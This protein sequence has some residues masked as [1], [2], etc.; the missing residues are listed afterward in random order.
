MSNGRVAKAIYEAFERG[1]VPAVLA[2]LDSAVE[3]RLA[4]GHPFAPTGEAW[5]GHDAVERFLTWAGVEWDR[6]AVTLTALH[7]AGD[8][9]VAEVRY[10]GTFRPA[11]RQLD[12]QGCHIWSLHEGKVTRF[13]QYVDT[14]QLQAVMT[15][16]KETS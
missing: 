10:S 8:T 11:G 4:E 9:L 6:F 15:L 12:A 3:W 7:D 1:D 16:E 5:V 2:Q 14:G 13:Q